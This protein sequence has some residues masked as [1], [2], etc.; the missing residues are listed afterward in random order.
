MQDLRF[1]QRTNMLKS[2]WMIWQTGINISDIWSLTTLTL[3]M[4]T[5]EIS[6]TFIIPWIQYQLLFL[7]FMK[8]ASGTPYHCTSPWNISPQHF[9]LNSFIVIYIKFAYFV[10]KF[11]FINFSAHIFTWNYTP[12][13]GI[14]FLVLLLILYCIC[15]LHR[16]PNCQKSLC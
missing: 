3:T 11:I 16:V 8:N 14:C 10:L 7:C 12:Y 15:G 4:K 6:K 2:S 1:S 9:S 13:S 5:E